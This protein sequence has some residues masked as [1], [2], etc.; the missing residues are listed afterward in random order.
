MHLRG[1]VDAAFVVLIRKA[2]C[3][4]E[5]P[6]KRLA[7]LGQRALQTGPV[8]RFNN[9]RRVQVQLDVLDNA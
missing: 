4:R 3:D 8:E 7:L 2:E 9:Q 6:K 1:P 5:Q